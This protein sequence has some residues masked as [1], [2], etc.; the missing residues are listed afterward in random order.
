MAESVGN[1]IQFPMDL[2]A[3]KGKFYRIGRFPGVIGCTDCTHIRI[4]CPNCQQGEN[5]RNRK[6]WY[7][8]NVQVVGE[9]N[10]EIFDIIN[11]WPGRVHFL[12][13]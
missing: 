3:V 2:E 11:Q 9:P 8:L 4:K 7:S 12:V 13:G 6:G 1:F 5:F 10:L